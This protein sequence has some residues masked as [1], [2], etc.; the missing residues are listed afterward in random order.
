MT[1]NDIIVELYN[2]RTIEKLATKFSSQIGYNDWSDFVQHIYL[3]L[4][5]M[6]ESK[7]VR[8][9]ESNELIYY[10]VSI[11]RNQAV[12]TNSD[13]HRTY[14]PVEFVELDNNIQFTDE[15]QAMQ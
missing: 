1:R 4:L 3:I 5:N 11:I 14:H 12:N 13:F 15:N 8:L 2:A 10:V 6:D 9:Y 7:L